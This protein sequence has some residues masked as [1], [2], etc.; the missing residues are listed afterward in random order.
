MKCRACNTEVSDDAK[1]C[2]E[3]GA[4]L[5]LKCASCGAIHPPQ[6]KFCS[7]CGAA[8]AGRP[9]SAPQPPRPPAAPTGLIADGERRQLTV[10]FSDI[11]GSTELSAHLDPE[12]FREVLRAYHQAVEGVISRYG[13]TVAQ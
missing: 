4:A 10:L 6:A 1:F 13:G 12:D 3:C 8:V 11:V 7:S 5:V 2:L 9:A